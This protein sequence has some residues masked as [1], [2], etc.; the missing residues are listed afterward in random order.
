[1][2]IEVKKSSVCVCVC[3]CVCHCPPICN[4]TV[5]SRYLFILVILNLVDLVQ[6]SGTPQSKTILWQFPT[7]R[8]T[9]IAGIQACRLGFQHEG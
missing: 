7:D 6:T 1:M 3:V 8:L 9:D 2:L 5:T 4:D